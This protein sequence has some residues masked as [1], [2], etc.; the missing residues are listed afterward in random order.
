MLLRN[1][2]YRIYPTGKQKIRLEKQFEICKNLHNDLL[3]ISKETYR[4]S[5]KSV[6]S[7]KDLYQL[8]NILKESYR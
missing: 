2:K 1:Y 8:T 3:E 4:C 6:T 5:G 7:R